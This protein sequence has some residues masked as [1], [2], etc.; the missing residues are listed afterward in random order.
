MDWITKFLSVL[1]LILSIK[2]KFFLP[3]P[4]TK[5]FHNLSFLSGKK[6][7]SI[8]KAIS[9][10]KIELVDKRNQI[11]DSLILF[12]EGQIAK[13]KTNVDIYLD[14]SVGIGEHS[15]VLASIQ[16]EINIISQYDEQ[17]GVL[18]KYFQ[19]DN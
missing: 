6:L 18:K 4:E 10:G 12:A 7:N 9:G 2:V 17:I 15:D 5:I 1:N 19:K 11:I 3:P 16:E 14:N 13:H 8:G